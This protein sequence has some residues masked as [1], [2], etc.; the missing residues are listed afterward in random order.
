[1]RPWASA[2]LASTAV[3]PGL[4]RHVTRF[5]SVLLLIAVALA[6]TA[7]AVVASVWWWIPA[8]VL[9]F[10][11]ATGVYDLCQRR[12]AVLRNY[13][14]LG[15][16]RYMLEAIRPELQQYFIERNHD[17]RPY[18]RDTRD[19]VYE[20]AKGTAAEEPF[21][22][23][24]N[25]YESGYEFL[26]PSIAPV[27]VPQDP[28]T[29]RIG[30]PECTKPYDMALMNVSAMSFGSLSANAV[31]A[32]NHG[33]ALGGFAHDTGE[34]GL[35]EY[36][37]RHGGDLVWEIGTGYFGCRTE[38]GDFDP[39][40]FARKAAHEQVKCVSLK[41]SQGAK[42]GIGGVL[43]GDKVNAE[44]ARV[45]GVPEGETV[46]SPRTTG[47]SPPRANSCASSPACG[48]C[49]AASRPASSCA[50]AHGAMCWPCARRCWPRTSPPTSSSSTARRAAPEPLRWSSATTSACR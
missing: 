17:G 41:L 12:H 10:L 33:A 22:S 11:S 50:S 27:P 47:S 16:M 9:L 44:I 42:P 14:V 8:A 3:Y 23:E 24:R 20:R 49:Q 37:L 13:P 38:D 4:Q 25:V 18:D 40:Q 1:M 43:P 26:V 28:P 21:G 30:G 39:D 2:R 29:V 46:I 19:L 48:T 34:G 31:L 5:A 35:S 45:R 7:S 6:T 32:L 15:H 36:H